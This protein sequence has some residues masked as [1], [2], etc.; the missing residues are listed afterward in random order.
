M[1]RG[2]TLAPC[3]AILNVSSRIAGARVATLAGLRRDALLLESY[4]QGQDLS[5]W[6]QVGALLISVALR[7]DISRRLQRSSGSCSTRLSGPV[8]VSAARSW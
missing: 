2:C 1:G 7:L 5:R 8:W 3:S 4:G 6:V